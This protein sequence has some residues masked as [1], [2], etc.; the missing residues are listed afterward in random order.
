MSA[1]YS[2]RTYQR[3]PV[4][5][6]LHYLGPECVGKGI[7]LNLSR[8]G[9]RIEGECAVAPGTVLTL[10]VVCP[11]ETVPIMVDRA[12]VRWARE[13]VFGI[14]IVAMRRE[15]A[16]RLNRFVVALVRQHVLDRRIAP[17]F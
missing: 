5:C 17:S 9:W 12:S 16:A 3:F 6:R 7:V 2:I 10:S 1:Q 11:H 13:G 15:E 14:Q 4:A 8:M